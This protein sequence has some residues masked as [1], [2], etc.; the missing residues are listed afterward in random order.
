VPESQVLTVVVNG[1]RKEIT[2]GSSVADFI[3]GA[4]LKAER[5]AIEVNRSIIRRADWPSTV[6]T[7]GDRI[8]V[9]HFVGGG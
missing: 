5:L 6:L 9:V 8:E 3:A 7:E 4:G 1:E 2:D